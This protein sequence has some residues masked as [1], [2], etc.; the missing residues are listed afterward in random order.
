MTTAPLKETAGMRRG[1]AGHLVVRSSEGVSR[2][3]LK[4]RSWYQAQPVVYP[5][6]QGVSEVEEAK[7]RQASPSR[8][9]VGN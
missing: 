9:V 5:S 8:E 6:P 4:A 1:P 2:A 3:Q 7:A